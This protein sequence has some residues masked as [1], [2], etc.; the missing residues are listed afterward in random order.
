MIVTPNCSAGKLA[1]AMPM[2]MPGLRVP[3]RIERDGNLVDVAE[4]AIEGECLLVVADGRLVV[5][6]V[7]IDVARLSS[8]VASPSGSC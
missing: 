8:V 1:A 4:G 2:A 5:A 7:V 3:Q 6:T